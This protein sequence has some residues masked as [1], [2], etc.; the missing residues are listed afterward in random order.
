MQL[1][2]SQFEFVSCNLCGATDA[3]DVP[4]ATARLV[5]P[6]PLQVVRCRQCGFLYVNPRLTRAAYV[7]LSLTE[8]YYQAYQRGAVSREG[9]TSTARA[10]LER[11]RRRHPQPER[12][13]EIGCAT[14]EFLLEARRAGWHTSGVEPS[15]YM[16]DEARKNGLIV[17]SDFV[18]EQYGANAFDVVH[19][20][21]VLEHVPEPLT[22]L[23][24]IAEVLVPGGLLVIEVPYELGGWFQEVYRL[25]KRSS[26]TPNIHHL[27]FFT[28]RTLALALA[29]AGFEAQV[30]SSSPKHRASR[31]V[32]RRAGLT[33]MAYVTDVFNR[34]ENIEAFATPRAAGTGREAK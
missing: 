3:V 30:R 31:S 33:A 32:W 12:I 17:A 18:P 11:I 4:R 6:S 9:R 22:T 26:R 34:G 5:L 27:S 19:M 24:G 1:E 16:A 28:P 14:G 15:S 2:A 25:V 29:N 20:N 10:Q 7:Q 23:R 8:E 13:L 21:H